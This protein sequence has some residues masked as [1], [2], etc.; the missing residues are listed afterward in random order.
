MSITTIMHI[1]AHK[2]EHINQTLRN[3]SMHIKAL[4]GHYT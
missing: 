1:F 4:I 2:D 3:T